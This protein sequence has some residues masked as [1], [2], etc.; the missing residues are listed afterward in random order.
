MWY[1]LC[2]VYV[3][4]ILLKLVPLA[5]GYEL[6]LDNTK[7]D[8]YSLSV[9]VVSDYLRDTHKSELVL[10]HT[11]DA[12]GSKIHLLYLPGNIMLL[13]VRSPSLDATPSMWKVIGVT[14]QILTL[15]ESEV[16]SDAYPHCDICLSTD[17]SIVVDH[18][19]KAKAAVL[20]RRYV[21]DSNIDL[22]LSKMLTKAGGIED[23]KSMCESDVIKRISVRDQVTTL[24]E[25]SLSGAYDDLSSVESR[26]M[27]GLGIDN[28][29]SEDQE[30]EDLS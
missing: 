8:L 17:V 22:Y 18:I 10:G 11:Q 6:H 28:E 7:L 15:I 13:Q 21:R 16:Y 1:S 2:K 14:G 26:L 30:E 23:Y 20:Y 29:G 5:K 27:V 4:D 12:S 25:A 3:R 24:I 9:E 19:G